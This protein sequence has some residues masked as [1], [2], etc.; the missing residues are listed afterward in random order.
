ML[1]NTVFSLSDAGPVQIVAFFGFAIATI[2]FFIW[3][4]YLVRE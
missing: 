3:V 4:A 2:A 1:A